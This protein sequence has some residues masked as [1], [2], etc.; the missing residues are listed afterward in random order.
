[1]DRAN[2][3]CVYSNFL[4]SYPFL[5]TFFQRNWILALIF[6]LN[7]LNLSDSS[8]DSKHEASNHTKKHK[9]NDRPKKVVVANFFFSLAL[10]MV[11]V[12]QPVAFTAFFLSDQ[13]KGQ[14]EESPAQTS[15][16]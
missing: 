6:C 12:G 3:D 13:G 5:P 16:A 10:I 14:R 2:A 9:Q 1:M 11:S 4:N 7:E 15:E 8:S